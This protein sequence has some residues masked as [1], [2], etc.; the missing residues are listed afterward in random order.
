MFTQD[1]CEAWAERL[2]DRKARNKPVTELA[3]KLQLRKLEALGADTAIE[4][5]HAAI[6]GGWTGLHDPGGNARKQFE[7]AAERDHENMLD[8]ANGYFNPSK[9]DPGTELA[10][11]PKPLS[12]T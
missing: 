3:A 2:N 8:R 1:F 6:A 4:W 11:P 5:I 7:S 9:L 10:P 12:L